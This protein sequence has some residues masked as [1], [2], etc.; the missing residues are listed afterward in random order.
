MGRILKENDLPGFVDTQN[1][2]FKDNITIWHEGDIFPPIPFN[3]G[4]GTLPE[5]FRFEGNTWFNA[6]NP[7]NSFVVLP[8][9]ESGGVYGVDP[10]VGP[11]SVIPWQFDWGTW[12]VNATEQP[13]AF[14]LGTSSS[15][16]LAT[17]NEGAE[18]DL[19]KPDPLIG[20]WTLSPLSSSVIEL[21]PFSHLV[22]VERTP[23][24]ISGD[25]NQ[26]GVVD[27][28]DYTIWRHTLGSMTE[29]QAD[30]DNSGTVDQ[31]D[32]AVWTAN[33]GATA[34]AQS[35]TGQGPVPEPHAA[36]LLGVAMTV[37]C[38][39]ARANHGRLSASQLR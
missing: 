4:P 20:D 7:A 9:Q 6:T 2:E 21:D 3:V 39:A 22:L 17:P 35:I 10:Q 36:M 18:L 15:H 26:N 32:Y 27:A 23:E 16:L 33:F 19:G 34:P 30:G 5:T 29:L 28:A 1:G 11:D 25:Y 14:D 13:Q 31:G 24:P 8:A 37:F 12:L 38:A